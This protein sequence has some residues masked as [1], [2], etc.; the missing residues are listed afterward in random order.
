[1]NFR[2][3][4]IV[5]LVVILSIAHIINNV[6][7]KKLEL[8]NALIWFSLGIIYL[9]FDLIPQ[10]QVIIC[11]L[12]GISIPQNMLIFLALGLILCILYSQT[13]VISKQGEV[14]KRLIQEIGILQAEKDSSDK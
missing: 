6:L 12:L 4:I 7:K 5:A 8:K 13:I 2:L 10:L 14:I 11:K 3:Q 9:I 1:M